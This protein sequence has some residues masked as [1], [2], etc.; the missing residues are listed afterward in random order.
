MRID[1]MIHAARVFHHHGALLRWKQFHVMIGD[2]FHA[3]APGA[4]VYS[5]RRRSED[6]GKITGGKTPDAIHL[7]QSVLGGNVALQENGILPRSGYD[8]GHAT[9]VALHSSLAANGCGDFTGN[10]RER[11]KSQPV[12]G[13]C[14]KNNKSSYAHIDN[15]YQAGE[16]HPIVLCQTN[17]PV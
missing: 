15:A 2:C 14:Q 9:S 6:F 17:G 4:L 7:P 10:F 11:P 12:D 1:E 13:N 8:M 5:K 3:H 16:H